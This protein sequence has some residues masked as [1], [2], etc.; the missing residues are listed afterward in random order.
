MSKQMLQEHLLKIM[1][2]IPREGY[3]KNQIK[4]SD[5]ENYTWN[6]V[7]IKFGVYP[8]Q[9]FS[10]AVIMSIFTLTIMIT[11]NLF[12]NI[13][14][15]GIF[16]FV[17]FGLALFNYI[18]NYF[19][20]KVRSDGTKIELLLEIIRFDVEL[21]I[22]SVSEKEDLVIRIL[23][24]LQNYDEVLSKEM[25]KVIRELYR[26]KQIVDVLDELYIPSKSFR[27]F[28]LTIIENT[29]HIEFLSLL[30]N[31]DLTEKA[32]V[33]FTKSLE[34]RISILFFIGIFFPIGIALGTMLQQISGIYL[35]LSIPIFFTIMLVLKRKFMVADIELLGQNNN[36]TV[37][38]KKEYSEFLE[39]YQ[40][41][42]KHLLEYSPEYS[43]IKAYE[44][45]GDIIKQELKSLILE[46]SRYRISIEEFF[47]KIT[48]VLKN[49]RIRAIFNNTKSSIVLN[50]FGSSDRIQKTIKLINKNL[51]KQDEREELVKS[52]K[53]KAIIFIGLM[54]IILGVLAGIMP[55]FSIL[56]AS[57]NVQNFQYGG[58]TILDA[59]IYYVVQMFFL[60]IINNGFCSIIGIKKQK[61]VQTVSTIIFFASSVIALVGS[62]KMSFAI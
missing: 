11:I 45:S 32:Y 30:E 14:N 42:S 52:E 61:L 20:K 39:F 18:Y 41:F 12:A 31:N 9:A 33:R 49:P 22:N 38:S 50:S 15:I 48:T 37:D 16:L 56:S 62:S 21:L 13:S 44:E 6:Q 60:I 25:R 54:P 43:L 23:T 46:I 29:S 51:R 4:H 59:G 3:I 24:L 34:S 57:S 53:F 7:V 58:F 1:S 2:N 40:K 27:E 26:G 5:E 10:T 35:L 17:L 36:N 47:T 19:P 8:S 28:L 55:T